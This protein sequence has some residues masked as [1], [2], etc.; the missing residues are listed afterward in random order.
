MDG[1]AIL[2]AIADAALRCTQM[3]HMGNLYN[4]VT[5]RLLAW[6]GG[7]HT[8][9]GAASGPAAPAL[10]TLTLKSEPLCGE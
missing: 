8:G 2:E 10:A 6:E 5:T 1:C 7:A 3:D 4:L 9:P